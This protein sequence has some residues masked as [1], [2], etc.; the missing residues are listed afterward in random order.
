MND[1]D[2]KFLMMYIKLSNIRRRQG[3]DFKGPFLGGLYA[4]KNDA[5]AA[6]KRVIVEQRG[7]AIIPKIFEVTKS[8]Q[9]AHNNALFEFK[10]L[11]EEIR[12][13]DDMVHKRT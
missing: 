9:A 10:R 2:E 5:E 3:V 7:F 12:E 6:I 1:S 11:K 13:A 4:T 8:I